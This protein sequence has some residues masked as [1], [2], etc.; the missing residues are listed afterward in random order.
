MIANPIVVS[1][2]AI[3]ITNIENILLLVIQY[4]K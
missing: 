2:A 3:I 1:D 4:Q